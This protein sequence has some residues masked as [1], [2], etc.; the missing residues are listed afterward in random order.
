M[1][2]VRPVCVPEVALQGRA[3]SLN[4]HRAEAVS[5]RIRV[6]TIAGWIAAAVSVTF[7]TFQLTIGGSL[8]WLGV[9]NILCGLA[10]LSIPRLCRSGR[11]SRR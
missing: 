4:R 11:S 2:N 1:L 8:W 6:L 7:G 10:F 3:T 9:I 5:R